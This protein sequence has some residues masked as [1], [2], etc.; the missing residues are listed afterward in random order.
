MRIMRCR[1]IVACLC[2]V[3]FAGTACSLSLNPIPTIPAPAP[4]PPAPLPP[5]ASVLPKA[6]TDFIVTLPEPLA[7]GEMLALGLL[8]EV[9]GLA[10]NTQLFPMQ[11][12]DGLTYAATLALPLNAVMKY[13]YVRLGST[14]RYFITEIGRAHV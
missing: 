14:Q 2:L 5:S 4:Q 8:D 12:V 11:S 6:Q 9:T 1:A 13:R 3:A 10:L 7:A